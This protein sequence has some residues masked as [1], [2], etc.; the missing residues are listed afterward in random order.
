MG[1]DVPRGFIR[2]LIGDELLQRRILSGETAPARRCTNEQKQGYPHLVDR[3]SDTFCVD[4]AVNKI[5]IGL[6]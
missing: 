2:K 3:V 6:C 5:V 4:T 1:E